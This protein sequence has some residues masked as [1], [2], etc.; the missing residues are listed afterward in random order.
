[1]IEIYKSIPNFEGMYSVSNMGNVIGHAR[2]KKSHINGT[3]AELP[4]KHLKPYKGGKEKGYLRVSLSKGNKKTIKVIHRM[5]AELFIPN[6]QNKPC[7][8]HID[9]NK[10]NNCANNLEWCTWSENNIHYYNLRR[11]RA[12]K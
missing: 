9:G 1:M 11:S 12:I 6:L 5:V 7:V 10:H 2:L 8:N 4:E 3:M